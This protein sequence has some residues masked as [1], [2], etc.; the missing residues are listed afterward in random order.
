MSSSLTEHP[1]SDNYH[2]L[3]ILGSGPAGLTA[4]LYAARADLAPLVL[5]G[6]QPGGQLTITTDVENYPGFPEGILGPELMDRMREQARRFGTKVKFEAA[7]DVDF[8]TRPFTIRTDEATYRCDALIVSTGA[9]AKLD[10]V[11]GEQELMGYGVS[12]CATCDGFFFR[13]KEIVVIGGGDS[14][15]EEATYLTKFASKVTVI[16]RRRELRASKIMQDRAFANPKIA[17]VWDSVVTGILGT[18]EGGVTGVKLHNRA[19]ELDSVYPT[20]GVFYAIGH[21]PNTAIFKGKLEMNDVGYIKV[22][23]PTTK[24]SVH[25][26]FAA[27]DAMDPIY[28]QAVTSAGTGCRAAID[29][30]RW[31]QELHD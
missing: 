4:A 9:T 22:Q 2:R 17:W 26:V 28:R 5:E 8:E 3:M 24:T 29:A 19:T 16:H 13:D 25:G 12:A 14:A 15:M 31:L 20:Q 6:N 10:G 27:G 21:Q 23:E 30:E 18:R 7:V 11:P 1:D